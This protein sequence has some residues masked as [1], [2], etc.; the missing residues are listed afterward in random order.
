M[1]KLK[2][3]ILIPVNK[4]IINNESSVALPKSLN[5]YVV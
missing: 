2:E 3:V 4:A 1:N 5:L